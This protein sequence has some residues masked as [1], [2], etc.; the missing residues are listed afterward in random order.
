MTNV[1][2]QAIKPTSRPERIKEL[3]IIRGFALFGVLLVNTAMFNTTLMS[4][5]AMGAPL[6]NP[7]NVGVFSDKLAALFIQLFGEG[8]FYTIFSFLFGLG[9]CIFMERAEAKGCSSKKLFRRRSFFLLLFGVLNFSL[10]WYGDI[11]H[12]YGIVGF[13]LMLFINRSTK[14]IRNWIIGL[15]IFST[16]IF[17]GF[18]LLNSLGSALLPPQMLEAQEASVKA[19]AEKSVEIY[20]DGS[21]LDI[22]GYRLSFES[23]FILMNL[24]FLMPKILGMFLIGLYVGK[25]KIFS[26]I[27]GNMELIRKTWRIGGVVGIIATLTYALIQSEVIPFNQILSAPI[28][29]FFK[30]IATVSLSLFYITSLIQLSRKDSFKKLLSPLSYMGQMALTNYLVQCITLSLIFYGHGL[31]LVYRIGVSLGVLITL[32]IYIAQIFIS[33]IWLSKFKYGPFEW[34]WRYLTYKGVV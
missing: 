2:A 34:V 4:K 17:F 7:W 27:E 33:K 23:I 31:G 30:E 32:A 12:V 20:Q 15:L 24:V 14:T 19:M 16:V 28:I 8:K 6:T 5:S 29:T 3:D 22:V 21:F 11:L 9:F 25:R 18:I 26:D 10:V 1:E 13:L